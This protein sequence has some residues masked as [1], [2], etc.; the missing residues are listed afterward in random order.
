[1]VSE[2]GKL[3][4]TAV[5]PVVHHT[6]QEV[7]A[8]DLE[9]LLDKARRLSWEVHGKRIQFFIP[10]QMVYMGN[11]GKYPS[12]SLTGTYCALGCEHCNRKI[13]EGM[14]P[15]PEP[16]ILEELC[17]RFYEE[18]NIGVL[19]SGGSDRRGAL[20]WHA[21]LESIRWIKQ[22]TNLKVSI[23]TGLIDS[24]T[25]FA[26]RDA[27]I[28]EVLIDVI[29]SDETM[30]RVCHLSSGIRAMKSSLEALA[31]AGLPLIPHIVVGLHY[32]QI[33]GEM[34]A[35]EMVARHPNSALV[36]VVLNPMKQTPMEGV[37]PPE[38]EV[39]ARFIAAA[40]LRMPEVPISL[41]C[42]RPHG[43]HRVET[44]LMA[45]EAGINR[46]AMPSEEVL[47]RAQEAGLAIEF[48]KT[49]CS[50]SYKDERVSL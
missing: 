21:F 35:L 38:P 41:S 11:R 12:I 19:L 4:S 33:K 27:G 37:Q 32:G 50:K 46:I 28:D 47:E 18:G 3:G 5:A 40:R 13:L 22:H 30:H 48:H 25:A 7:G 8:W 42:F 20:P 9:E 44:D 10:G 24:K 45:V 14:I 17:G 39:V 43:R 49:C 6:W 16:Q 23:H 29:G 15:A 2:R 36:I 31:D 26:L 34:Q 1:M